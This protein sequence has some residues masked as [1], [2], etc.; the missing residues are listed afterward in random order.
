MLATGAANER[1]RK[2]LPLLRAYTELMG[3]K[4]ALDPELEAALAK[5]DTGLMIAAD[6]GREDVHALVEILAR[7]RG[8]CFRFAADPGEARLVVARVESEAGRKAFDAPIAI[9]IELLPAWSRHPAYLLALEIPHAPEGAAELAERLRLLLPQGALRAEVSALPSGALRVT[10]SAAVLEFVVATLNEGPALAAGLETATFPPDP[11]TPEGS[12]PAELPEILNAAFP[13]G[14]GDLVLS[15]DLAP[16]TEL[17]ILLAFGRWARQ[18]LLFQDDDVRASLAQPKSSVDAPQSV[19]AAWV[20][21]FVSGVLADAGCGVAPMPARHPVLWMVGKH[22]QVGALPLDP[23]GIPPIRL[24]HLA[25]VAHLPAT[26]F[27]TFTRVPKLGLEA[28]VGYESLRSPDPREPF[29]ITRLDDQGLFSIIG[30]PRAITSAVLA[31]RLLLSTP[32]E[33]R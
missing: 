19:P 30:T 9:P 12:K 6:V 27:Q 21:E 14:E 8:P 23:V 32:K 16:P 11:N 28:L 7:A 15:W 22:P 4:L 1:S 10:G 20:R 24:K 18:P 31:L 17:D 33:Q 3:W 25:A 26:R 2:L 13:R 5:S 29:W